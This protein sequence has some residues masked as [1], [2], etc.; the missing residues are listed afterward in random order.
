M[1]SNNALMNGRE[2]SVLQSLDKLRTG[3][4]GYRSLLATGNVLEKK[5]SENP[6]KNY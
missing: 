3:D 1:A 2:F 5:L 6:G 4:D